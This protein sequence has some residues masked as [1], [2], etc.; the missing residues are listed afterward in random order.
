MLNKFLIL[1]VLNTEFSKH[2]QTKTIK[3]TQNLSLGSL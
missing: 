1:K 3:S 2:S